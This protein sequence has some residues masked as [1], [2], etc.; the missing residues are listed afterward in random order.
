MNGLRHIKFQAPIDRSYEN[1][2]SWVFVDDIVFLL[3]PSITSWTLGM[4]A[5]NN[6]SSLDNGR[7]IRICFSLYL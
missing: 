1:G 5:N 4:G 3:F 2:A 6:L 7:P